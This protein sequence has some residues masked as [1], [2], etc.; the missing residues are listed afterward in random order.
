MS[1]E[2][3]VHQY[4]IKTVRANE[5]S[6]IPDEF[7]HL[8]NDECISQYARKFV[9]N[10]SA[11]F[12]VIP[13]DVN[14]SYWDEVSPYSKAHS[15]GPYSWLCAAMPK[16]CDPTKLKAQ[17]ED[18]KLVN[19]RTEPTPIKYCLSK[20]VR[21]RCRVAMSMPLMAIVVGC[22]VLK[23]AGLGLTWIFLDKKPLLTLGGKV[24]KT[25][26]T[27]QAY[28]MWAVV[29]RCAGVLSRVS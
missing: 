26:P 23:L 29:P 13:S 5:T 19:W 3:S 28:L 18:W 24:L 7:E 21:E 9:T 22:N 14:N 4:G 17:S 12:I 16:P 2:T 27:S 8:E 25:P 10:R 20:P 15:A 11:L 1:L 6:T